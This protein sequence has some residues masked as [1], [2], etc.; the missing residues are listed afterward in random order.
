MLVTD[1]VVKQ[2]LLDVAWYGHCKDLLL[3]RTG[4]RIFVCTWPAGSL[5]TL[6]SVASARIK[7]LEV[8]AL[9]HCGRKGK[10]VEGW[11]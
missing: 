3:S 5:G 4:V 7:G 8:H 11:S 6:F 9:C 1:I 2:I 10:S